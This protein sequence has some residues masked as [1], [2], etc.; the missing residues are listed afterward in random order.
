MS[1]TTSSCASTEGDESTF[2]AS[3][4]RHCTRPFVA[5]Y[6]LLRKPGR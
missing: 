6:A 3:V 1:T 2:V 4:A 5:A